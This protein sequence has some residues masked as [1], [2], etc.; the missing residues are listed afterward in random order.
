MTATMVPTY[1]RG[2][3]V[4]IGENATKAPVGEIGQV[5]SVTEGGAFIVGVGH[6]GARYV[7]RG[8]SL[9]RHQ[10]PPPGRELVPLA[11]STVDAPRPATLDVAAI[12]PVTFAV[13]DDAAYGT[14]PA[15][16]PAPKPA[17]TLWHI[18]DRVRLTRDQRDG[19]AAGATG[20]I[21]GSSAVQGYFQVKTDAGIVIVAGE[22]LEPDIPDGMQ[23]GEREAAARAAQPQPEPTRLQR[24]LRER[25]QE[26][27]AMS[28]TGSPGKPRGPQSEAHKRAI[29]DGK[30]RKKAEREAREQLAG[31]EVET[32]EER[33]GE[34]VAATPALQAVEPPAPPD[35]APLAR[36]RFSTPTDQP[37]PAMGVHD[38][39]RWAIGVGAE[40]HL[41]VAALRLMVDTLEAVEREVLHG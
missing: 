24:A 27:E 7:L 37:R 4:V 10:G 6:M 40:Q 38:A 16:P 29:A 25:R 11:G 9:A 31:V 18:G 28:P 32:L 22:D 12:N 3:W 5:V 34:P 2:D 30:A 20:R 39:L 36:Q 1:Q 41:S 8:A 21:F 35:P 17:R 23:R 14:A 33:E 13:R 15:T 19:P 26:S